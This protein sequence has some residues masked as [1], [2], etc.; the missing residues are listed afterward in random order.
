MRVVI[1]TASSVYLTIAD[2]GIGCNDLTSY[3]GDTSNTTNHRFGLKLVLYSLKTLNGRLAFKSKEGIGT[4]ARL[5]L[6]TAMHQFKSDD[7]KRETPLESNLK[8]IVFLVEDDNSLREYVGELLK[9]F[10]DCYLFSNAEDALGQ[11]VQT[12]PDLI[13][14]DIYLPGMDGISFSKEVLAS[15]KTSH[16]PILFLTGKSDLST[17]IK[18]LKSF[19]IDY[20]TKPFNTESFSLK[21]SNLLK[22]ITDM[23]ARN[24]KVTVKNIYHSSDASTHGLSQKDCRFMQRFIDTIEI[25]YSD[26]NYNLDLLSKDMF[27]SKTQLTRKLKAITS[28]TPIEYLQE[29]RLEKC[30]AA[31]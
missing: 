17:E 9:D 1:H 29:Y 14:T 22:V 11:A 19:A 10:A 2:Y 31:A 23:R 16:I 18:A 12:I 8:P 4:V 30:F 27:M 28:K 3:L 13:I 15:E 21:V 24:N 5:S 20:I 6:P 26:Q 25:N 7:I